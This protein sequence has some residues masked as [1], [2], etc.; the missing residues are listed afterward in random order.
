MVEDK[1]IVDA[2]KCLKSHIKFLQGLLNALNRND[3]EM[4]SG[5]LWTAWCLHNYINSQLV[6][7]IERE[8]NKRD[9]DNG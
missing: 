4:K 2:K 9:G 1:S 3:V 6:L 7:D 8:I 5:A